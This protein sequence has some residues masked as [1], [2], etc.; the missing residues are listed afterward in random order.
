VGRLLARIF[1]T[2]DPV[3]QKVQR[4][5]VAALRL[6]L[7]EKV[8]ELKVFTLLRLSCIFSTDDPVYRC[9]AALWPPR[10]CCCWEGQ[11]KLGCSLF[12]SHSFVQQ[13]PGESQSALQRGGLALAALSLAALN[14]GTS[15]VLRCT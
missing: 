6:L 13:R 5:I 15:L 7:L 14:T 8:R 2:D 3:Y 4:G 12:P 1:S 11:S 9:S 10:A